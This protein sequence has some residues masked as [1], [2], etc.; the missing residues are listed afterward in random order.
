MLDGPGLVTSAHCVRG[1]ANDQ[2]T[3]AA[4]A[5]WFGAFEEAPRMSSERGHLSTQSGRRQTARGASNGT[6]I[7]SA[8]EKV[9][10]YWMLLA[11]LESLLGDEKNNEDAEQARTLTGEVAITV[12]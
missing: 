2:L 10:E 12:A 9:A 7:K 5:A 1:G 3:N 11:Q 4:L 6:V 8:Y